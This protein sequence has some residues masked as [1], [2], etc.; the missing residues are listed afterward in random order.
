VLFAR[1]LVCVEHPRRERGIEQL[2]EVEKSLVGE[3][4]LLRFAN[5]LDVF[6]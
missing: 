4:N 1:T 6:L 3:L 5:G 2:R